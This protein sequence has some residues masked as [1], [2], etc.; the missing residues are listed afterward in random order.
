MF[1]AFGITKRGG[2]RNILSGVS[3]TLDR[4]E[5][6]VLLGPNGAGKTSLLRILAGI[7]RPD[8]GGVRMSGG[9]FDRAQ[10]GFSSHRPYLYEG[11]TAQENLDFFGRLYGVRDWS[12]RADELLAKLG[13]TLFRHEMV[14][15]F[16][17]GMQQRLDL[18]RVLLPGPAYLFLDE[19]YTGLDQAGMNVLDVLLGEHLQGKGAVII[20]THDLSR[21]PA[22][23]RVVFL[24][25]GRKVSE[26][27]HREL[28]EA[29]IRSFC[30]ANVVGMEVEAATRYLGKNR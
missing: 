16:S 14:R 3:L 19:P 5:C 23:G 18:A 24:R 8:G 27:S 13:M 9:V 11:L 17:R 30:A 29:E 4:G 1:E 22:K 25:R 21:L 2:Y 26:L 6:L 15:H 10:I 7:S 12:R 20:S 28:R